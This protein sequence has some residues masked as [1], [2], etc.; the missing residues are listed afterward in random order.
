MKKTTTI[1]VILCLAY[2]LSAQ[3]F[4][5]V[6]VLTHADQ[7]PYFPGCE[8]YENG[9]DDKR[10]CSNQHLIGYISTHLAYPKEAQDQA[11]EGVVYV[12]FIINEDG[13][14]TQPSILKD[15]GGGCGEAALTV[16][17]QMPMWESGI[18]EGKKVAIKLNLP[19]Q[20][21]LKTVDANL[22]ENYSISWGA[23]NGGVVQYEALR[24][25][26][27][28][29]ILVRDPLGST[30]RVNELVFVLEK[31]KR[32]FDAR[33]TKGQISKEL[34]KV[35]DKTKKG[36]KLTITAAIQDSGKLIWVS[37]SFKVEG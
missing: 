15:I 18:H 21:Y 5:P 29:T 10:Q 37:R 13:K 2:T 32:T 19:V 14:A 33:D 8:I 36:G 3:L 16:I 17:R 20:F 1:L 6:N 28:N 11:I 22:A 35:I 34:I 31:R 12:S 27:A 7:M 9:S 24:Q 30:H 23:L 4:D 25:N 26:I